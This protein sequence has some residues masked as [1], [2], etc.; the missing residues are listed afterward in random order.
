MLSLIK[1]LSNI[2]QLHQP[3]LALIFLRLCVTGPFISNGILIML[4]MWL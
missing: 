4:T 1:A 2:S 3:P